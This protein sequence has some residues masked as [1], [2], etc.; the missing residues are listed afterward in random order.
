M[1]T[2][3]LVAGGAMASAVVSKNLWADEV[4]V[5]KTLSEAGYHTVLTGK[6][7]TGELPGMRPHEVGFDEFQGYYASQ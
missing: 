6:W 1:A 2:S 7:Y 4:S 3:L 5:A